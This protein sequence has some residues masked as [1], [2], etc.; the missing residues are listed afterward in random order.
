MFEIIGTSRHPLHELCY[1]GE[2]ILTESQAW[3]VTF[4]KWQMLRKT[5]EEGKLIED[6][7]KSTC[8]L[9]ILYYYGHSDECEECP[10]TKAGHPGCGD[11]PYIEYRNAVKSG[12][13]STALK[14]T[15]KEN[16]FLRSVYLHTH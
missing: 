10:I 14:A 1:K 4:R 5:I 9:C 3:E 6:G 13:L 2:K 11:T 7:G 12:S 8:G 16:A 15:E